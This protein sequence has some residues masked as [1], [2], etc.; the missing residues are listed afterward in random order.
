[1]AAIKLKSRR[2][3]SPVRDKATARRKNRLQQA[4][5]D[6]VV[7]QFNDWAATQLEPLVRQLSS[8]IDGL[9]RRIDDLEDSFEQR[10]NE[11]AEILLRNW[12]SEGSG[13]R[14]NRRSGTLASPLSKVADE[15]LLGA[16]LPG[17][18]ESGRKR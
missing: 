7:S 3:R 10:V 17:S 6:K 5:R 2:T 12:I 15:G 4:V 16:A 18:F 8:K 9:E 14:P 13:T 1:M 11:V